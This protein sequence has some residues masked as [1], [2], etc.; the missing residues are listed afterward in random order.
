MRRHSRSRHADGASEPYCLACGSERIAYER[1]AVLIAEVV[2]LRDDVLFLA[3]PTAPQP[4]DD[5]HLVCADCDTELQDVSWTEERHRCVPIGCQPLADFEALD[6]LA[7]K[8]NEP[9]DWSGAD[10]C[11]LAATLLLRTG[12]WVEDEPDDEGVG[13]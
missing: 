6:M 12:R 5:V 1:D 10:V 2:A 4:L 13:S 8:L 9:G 3:G 7:A 11:E